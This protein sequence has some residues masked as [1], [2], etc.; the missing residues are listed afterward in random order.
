MGVHI[1]RVP[2]FYGCNSSP[3][4]T[5][6]SIDTPYRI[7]AGVWRQFSGPSEKNFKKFFYFNLI[8]EKVWVRPP[9]SRIIFA[10]AAQILTVGE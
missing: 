6:L 10:S 5:P 1:P 4:C 2:L 7:Y 8:S 3:N 9:Y